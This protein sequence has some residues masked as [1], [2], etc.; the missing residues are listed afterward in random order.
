[1]IDLITIVFQKEFFLIQTQA[2]SIEL[3]ID[4]TRINKIYVV[5]DGE[6]NEADLIDTSWW[7]INSHKVEIIARSR[8][9]MA[10]TLPGWERQQL[11]KLL[12]AEQATSQWSMCL[13]AKTW[14]VQPLDWNKLF[15]QDN[16][17]HFKS[18]PTIPAFKTAQDSIEKL[19]N[20]SL[21]RVIGPGGV[22]F[23]FY[24]PAV[25]LMVNDIEK[26]TNIS[27]FDFFTAN[28]LRPV[29][30]TEFMLYSGFITKQYKTYDTLYSD[31]QYYTVTNL[32]D[33]QLDQF[34]QVIECMSHPSNITASVQGRAY[35]HLSN[36]QL[37]RWLD[38]LLSKQLITDVNFT[39]S[40]LN[41]LK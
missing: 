30:M 14:F 9:G 5:V 10:H 20:I 38:F 36:E 11:Y 19:F 17:V 2:R 39:K 29:A 1:M 8:W 31:I 25:K 33:W 28:V 32:A 15:S 35:P 7:G 34:D 21:P 40:Q 27:F 37:D 22:P 41:T 3:Y 26:L 23:M 18:F 16:R 6:D 4:T 24:T 12:A 13:D